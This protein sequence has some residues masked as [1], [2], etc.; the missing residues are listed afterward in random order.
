MMLPIIE[1]VLRSSALVGIVWLVLKALRVHSPRLERSAWLLV[2]ASS[3]AMPLLME[4]LAL[5]VAEAPD[6]RWLLAID[7]V[8]VPATTAGINWQAALPWAVLSVAAALTL[9]HSLGVVRWWNVQRAG[10]RI[11]SPLCPGLDIR[12]TN[13]VS[14]P[15][16]VFSTVLVPLDFETL[17]RQAQHAVLAHE[18]AH[19]DNKDFYV[20]WIAQ[21]HRCVFWFSPLAWWL[22]GRLSTLGEHIS[23]DAAVRVTQER[24]AYAE[25]LL[26]FAT[27]AA[28]SEQLVT[29]ARAKTL[30]PRIE[31]ILAEGAPSES[32]RRTMWLLLA[33]L[34][35]LIGVAG[36]FRAVAARTHEEAV[37]SAAGNVVLPKS[38]PARPLSQP[39]YPPA[40]RRSGEH[41]TVVLKL[42]VLEDGSVADAVIAQSSGYPD[43]DYAAFYES[44]RWR[45][46]PG[47]IDG[48]PSRMWG[49][50]AVT[51]KL[52]SD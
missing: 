4:L 10:R 14:S 1:C 37:A 12:V 6:L 24:T 44:F 32:G 19:V 8:A 48:M 13:A 33:A 3:W 43:L 26:G 52:T 2:L 46:D 41:G 36:G 50:F 17:T 11:T 38:D 16:T 7:A 9:R 25:V 27:R 42:H 20:Q 45:L 18:R 30:G 47:T 28:R 23:D 51:F 5:P 31:R 34:L 22:A 15:A 21:L 49:R 40:S 35:P 39:A 29:M